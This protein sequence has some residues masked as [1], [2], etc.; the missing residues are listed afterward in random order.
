MR[1]GEKK[2]TK[3]E[4][5]ATKEPIKVWEVNFDILDIVISKLIET[6]TNSKYL[7]GYSNK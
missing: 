5:Y 4:L 2:V 6:K 1:L 3:E 7:I